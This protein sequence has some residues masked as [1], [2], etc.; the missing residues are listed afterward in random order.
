M[1]KWLLTLFAVGQ[2][3]ACTGIRLT[4]V[5]GSMVNGRTLEYGMDVP[6]SMEVIPRG[7]QMRGS[8]PMGAGLC[9][10]SK[11]ALVGSFLY[12]INFVMDG[13]NEK[14]LSV[15]FFLFPGFATYAEVTSENQAKALSPVEFP[16]WVLSQ[17]ATVDE[18][19]NALS[20]VVVVPTLYREY[21][22]TPP[23]L[24]YVVYDRKGDCIV[25]EPIDGKLVVTDNP[26][27]VLTNAPSLNWHLT[28]LSNYV[29]LH[30]EN[31][32][33]MQINGVTI[34]QLGQGSGMLGLP[35]D[36]TPP[37][38]FV[39]AAAFAN[40]AIPMATADASIVQLFHLF[41]QFDLPFGTVRDISGAMEKTSFTCA[42]DPQS[43]KFYFRTYQDQTI[44]MVD[45][46][47]FDLNARK[48]KVLGLTSTQPIVDVSG[49]LQ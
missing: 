3:I 42:R 11:Y 12:D 38:R 17:F 45:L 22:P 13:L 24:H 49:S 19:K 4:A 25:I 26:I 40:A 37:S 35:G 10:T 23:P 27:G 30:S 44:Q 7:N 8:T 6:L 48:I 21:G 9:F 15:S 28:N 47:K 36:F 32:A 5:D 16:T 33:P 34:S 31:A 18:V 29:N 43:L 39:R 2:A 46:N 14:G 41:N 20:N 1:R